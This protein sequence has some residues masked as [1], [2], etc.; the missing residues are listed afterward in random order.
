MND[1]ESV[2]MT[3]PRSSGHQQNFVDAVK[4]RSQPESNLAYARKMTMPMHLGLIS[5]QLGRKLDWN[6]EKEKFIG[7]K[8]ANEL[9]TRKKRKAYN[10]M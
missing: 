1:V 4:S 6:S 5:W 7:D 8:E 3:M 9:L 10:W 2:P